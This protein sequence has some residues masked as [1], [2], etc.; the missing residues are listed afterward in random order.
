M[1]AI[2]VVGPGGVGGLLAAR[3]GAAGH[4]VTV[5]STERTAAEL[6]ARGLRFQ[7]PDAA[8]ISS[9][10]T[11]QPWLTTA[12]DVLF[13]AVKATDLLPA[14]QRVPASVLGTA[15][16]VPLLNGVD[17]LSLL[18][19][20]YPSAAVIGASI[21]VEA[22][23][24]R[25]GV[26]EQLSP[27]ADLVLADGT[28]AGVEVAELARAAG[29]AVSTHP[30]DTTV[31]WS[32]LAFLAP[33]ALLTTGADAPIGQARDSH[34]SWLR[35][36]VDEAASAAGVHSVQVDA[37]AIT[38]RL[39]SLPGGMQSSMLKDFQAG[40]TLELDAIA[41]PIVRTLGA[42]KAATTIEVMQVILS[43]GR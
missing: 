41:G 40:R 14:L 34:E 21:A 6:T 19:A 11:A 22:T 17:H 29:L 27:F 9:F 16:V 3:F 31:L 26:I 42:A 2:G 43:A 23:R 37:D 25:P 8:P 39:T 32:K 12:L 33:L 7:G 4:A 1:A 36:L 13:V 24:H 30:D 28:S 20:A 35:P 5:I 10:P 15:T 38:A 18:R